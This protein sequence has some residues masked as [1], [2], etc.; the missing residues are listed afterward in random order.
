MFVCH[1]L[2]KDPPFSHIDLILCRRLLANLEPDVRQGVL[3]LLHYTLEPG[4]LLVLD[5]TDR[6]DLP[7]LFEPDESLPGAYRKIESSRRVPVLPSS[8]R[9]FRPASRRA[10]GQ[11]GTGAHVAGFTD[12]YLSA[13]DH[14]TPASVLIDADDTVVHF[15]SSASKYIQIPG[16]ELTRELPRLVPS[17]IRARLA[18]GLRVIRAGAKTWESEVTA[19]QDAGGTRNVVLRIE[20]VSGPELLLVVFD[21]RESVAAR[22]GLSGDSARKIEKLES[23]IRGLRDRLQTLGDEQDSIERPAELRSRVK[24]AA[25]ELRTVLDEL[26]AAKEELQTTNE[27][28]IALDSENRAR[29][30]ELTQIS[31]DLQHLLAATGIAT[32]FLDR[33]LKIVR[34]TP[35][36][37][38]LFGLRSS[39]IGRPIADLSRLVGRDSLSADAHTVLQTLLP[40]DREIRGTDQRWYLSRT[41]PYRTDAQIV[42]GAVITLIDITARKSAEEAVRNAS[43]QKDEFL[44][45]LAHELR[46]P[47]AA[48]SSG[49]EVLKVAPA[50]IQMVGRI[51]RTM[52]RQTRQLVR[53]VDDL[54]EVSRISGG[55][56]RLH[57]VVMDLRTVL[58][59]ALSSARLAIENAGQSLCAEIADEELRIRGDAARLTQVISNLL[60][61][62]MRY[63]RADGKITVTA[64]RDGA[65]VIMQVRDEGV[66]ISPE[67]LAHIF[68]MFYQG[69]ADQSQVG[70][71]IGLTLTKALVEMHGGSISAASPGEDQG[72]TF[73]IRIPI[74][75]A[76]GEL[77]REDN[78]ETVTQ[79]RGDHRILIVDDNSDAAESLSMLL[80]SMGEKEVH[81]ASS[82]AQALSA[83]PELHPDIVLLDLM[84]PEMD[85]YE[86]ARRMRN[87]PWGKNLFLIALS[88]LGQEEHRQ[89]SHEA[90]FD[91]HL[92]KPADL[93]VLKSVLRD[94]PAVS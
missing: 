2:F 92:T 65:N 35:L 12:T 6:F 21:D 40:L 5:S 50:D 86:V 80:R 78:I 16:G 85:G 23:E 34:F 61:N 75:R 19:I 7:E 46:N 28:L 42:Q 71:G 10:A 14:Y 31:T 41:L 4:G 24:E 39:D 11:F 60:S 54:L 81:T 13:I 63:N 1:D 15:S 56:L 8:L 17:E 74:S 38:D 82:G 90:G 59:E 36:L 3:R 32:L 33:E 84:M 76:T 49:V 29:L 26:A 18:E 44:A 67:A 43:R 55:K 62:A 93:T 48:I 45:I 91:R 70:L 94:T 88:G 66:G 30:A 83:V 72:S 68:E 27:E 89:R 37:G 77:R 57:P 79:P 53:L 73:T 47:L 51:S 22:S 64:A 58:E 87:E 25:K 69:R 9:P 20:Q 52:D